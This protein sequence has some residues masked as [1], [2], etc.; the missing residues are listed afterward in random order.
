GV[1][2]AAAAPRRAEALEDRRVGEGLEAAADRAQRGA[3]VEAGPVEDG[4][5]GPDPHPPVPPCGRGDQATARGI[6][7]A[8]GSWGKIADLADFTAQSAGKQGGHW[9]KGIW[10]RAPDPGEEASGWQ[11]TRLSSPGRNWIVAWMAGK[12]EGGYPPGRS[13]LKPFEQRGSS[14]DRDSRGTSVRG[15]WRP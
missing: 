3:V 6:P 9:G 14:T 11:R 10:P 2:G 1:I 8:R 15:G 13:G 4:L 5:H 7:R 12:L